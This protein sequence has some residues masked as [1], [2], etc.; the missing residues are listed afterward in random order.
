MSK[1]KANEDEARIVRKFHQLYY[2]Q[3]KRT[4]HNTYWLGVPVQKNP[5]DL[6]I[7]QEL[8][9]SLKPDLIVECGTASGGSA[10]FFASLCDLIGCG[11]I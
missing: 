1:D 3:W 4:W 6:W 9:H 10:L 2:D 5:L 7:Y 11:R 8:L